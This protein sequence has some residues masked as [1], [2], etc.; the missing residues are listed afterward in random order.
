MLI[1]LII[2]LAKE[3]EEILASTQRGASMLSIAQF[4]KYL[5]TTI[6]QGGIPSLQTTQRLNISAKVHKSHMIELGLNQICLPSKLRTYS[7]VS[8]HFFEMQV[9]IKSF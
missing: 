1:D 5:L 9:F 4:T 3:G 2:K 8:D 6:P 7:T